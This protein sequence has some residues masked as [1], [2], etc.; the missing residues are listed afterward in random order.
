MGFAIS[1]SLFTDRL[2]AILGLHARCGQYRVAEI[3][4]RA[5]SNDAA[6][7]PTPKLP[8]LPQ[9]RNVLSKAIRRSMLRCG[10]CGGICRE[11]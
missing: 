1:S 11:G 5:D 10:G 3:F 8:Q 7:A 4:F 2:V 6:Q 9:R